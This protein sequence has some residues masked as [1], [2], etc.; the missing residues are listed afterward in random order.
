[1]A[2]RNPAFAEAD[3][4]AGGA[5]HWSLVTFC[6]LERIAA[7]GSSPRLAWEAFERWY[8]LL[9]GLNDVGVARAFA[10]GPE[11]FGQGWRTEPY[12]MELPPGQ[13]AALDLED[14][15][16]GWSNDDFAWAWD[17]VQA[18]TTSPETVES[19]W[20]SNASFAWA[21]ADVV[22]VAIAFTEDPHVGPT[23]IEL[24]ESYWSAARTI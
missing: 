15:E 16:A 7:F 1:M 3:V 9:F 19:G 2:V 5:Q 23:E 8:P 14:Y 13:L 10:S 21:W 18:A 20:R 6:A 4:R 12:L 22:A 17:D 24:F 11:S